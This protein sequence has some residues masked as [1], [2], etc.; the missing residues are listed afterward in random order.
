MNTEVTITRHFELD[1]G[2]RLAYHEFKCQNVH[3]HRYI[4]DVEIT[5]YPDPDLGYVI[6]FSNVKAPVMDA[7][8]HNLLVNRDDPLF[9]DGVIASI[10]RHQAKTVYQMDCEPTVEN[11]AEESVALIWASMSPAERE[12]V[13]EIVMRVAETPNCTVELAV[14][15][16]HGAE[17][18][19]V[20]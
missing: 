5:G 14:E 12:N 6:D 18:Y 15:S 16:D 11:I 9:D 7:F 3:G 17:E 19:A 2:H 1:A 10:E 13:T 20:T 8:D 4:Y